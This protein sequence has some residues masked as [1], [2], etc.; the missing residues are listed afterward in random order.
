MTY[1]AS[2]LHLSSS[3]DEASKNRELLFIRWLD[4]IQP[5]ARKIYLLGDM[6]NF[7]FEYKNVIPC[8]YSRFFGKLARLVSKGT[9]VHYFTGNHD[10]WVRDYLSKEI[11]LIVHRNMEEIE[12]ESCRFFV[13]HG[14]E[15]TKDI[16]V[17]LL[18]KLY[19]TA[20]F[21]HFLAAMH[22]RWGI[23]LGNYLSEKN[24]NKAVSDTGDF[25]RNNHQIAFAT[26]KLR[27]KHYDYFIFGHSH[28]P[29]FGELSPNSVYINTGNWINHFSYAVFDGNRCHLKYYPVLSVVKE[30]TICLY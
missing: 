16:P 21:R 6:V 19:D 22:P 14:H 9:E 7:W 13:G 11:G 1:F 2:D 17:K 8:G 15:L 12:I 10:M 28:S 23:T 25:E 30:D 24:Q 26:Q 20:L 27:T 5:V 29:F 18:F 3:G 4:A